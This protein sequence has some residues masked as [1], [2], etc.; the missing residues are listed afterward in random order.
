MAMVLYVPDKPDNP[1]LPILGKEFEYFP[2]LVVQMWC[3]LL[4]VRWDLLP[5]GAHPFLRGPSSTDEAQR[6]ERAFVVVP[7]RV[8]ARASS[9][10]R[11]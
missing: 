4:D 11:V 8:C 1:K 6:A 2:K 7:Y 3:N 10:C 9:A 5:A